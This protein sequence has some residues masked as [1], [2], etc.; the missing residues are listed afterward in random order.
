M[1][2]TH[3]KGVRPRFAEFSYGILKDN[4]PAG[5]LTRLVDGKPVIDPKSNL[6]GVKIADVKGWA[7]TIDS[8][9]FVSNNCTG[10]RFENY[11]MISTENSYTRVDGTVIEGVN[12]V[13]LAMLLDSEVDAVWVYA[14]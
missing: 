7:P 14:D 13:A 12:D 11:E 1:T 4:K 10:E 6:A 5:I 3:T 8:L 9:D 2:Y